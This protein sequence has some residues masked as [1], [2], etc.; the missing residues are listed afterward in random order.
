[1]TLEANSNAGS[2]AGGSFQK[3]DLSAL[4][5]PKVIPT[6]EE[7]ELHRDWIE[8]L[9]QKVDGDCVWSKLNNKESKEVSSEESISPAVHH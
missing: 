4:E 7:L 6:E 9:D 3:I 1:L 2:E 5:L 8:R